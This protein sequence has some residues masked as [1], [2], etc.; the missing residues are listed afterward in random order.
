MKLCPPSVFH[1]R[2]TEDLAPAHRELQRDLSDMTA[3]I[4]ARE[5]GVAEEAD[6]H[7]M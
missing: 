7:W 1:I 5:G 6:C 3:F 2:H 4:W